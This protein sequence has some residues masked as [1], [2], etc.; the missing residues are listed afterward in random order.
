MSNIYTEIRISHKTKEDKKNYEEKL[1]VQLAVKGYTNR[2]VFIREKI[3]EL[4]KE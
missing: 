3:R 1:D 2:S 4:V